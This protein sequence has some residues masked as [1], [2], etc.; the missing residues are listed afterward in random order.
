MKTLTN[1]SYAPITSTVG[2]VRAPIAAVGEAL[3]SWRRELH[4]KVTAEHISVKFP[5]SL[6]RLEPLRFGW[7]KEMLISAGGWTAYFNARARGSDPVTSISVVSKRLNCEALKVDATPHDHGDRKVV[8]GRFGAVQLEMW[9]PTGELPSR[10]VRTLSVSADGNRWR[11]DQSGDVQPFEE[12][13]AYTARRIRDRLTTDMVERYCA[14]LGIDVFR[15]SFYGPESI[16]VESF[17]SY[18]PLAG[19]VSWSLEEA[20][21]QLAI[22]PDTPPAPA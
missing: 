9:G 14:A 1:E 5:V 8:G 10:Y 21:R 2:F 20:Q 22:T 4:P 13:D 18:P 12:P 7:N 17:P 15:E 3:L 19:D 11:F 16:V 6:R